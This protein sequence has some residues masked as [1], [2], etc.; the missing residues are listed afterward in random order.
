MLILNLKVALS[1]GAHRA[2]KFAHRRAECLRVRHSGADDVLFQK[3]VLL[4]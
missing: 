2:Q 1:L 3:K 4:H